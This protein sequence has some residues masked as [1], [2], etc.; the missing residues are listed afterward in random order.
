M[1]RSTKMRTTSEKREASRRGGTIRSGAFRALSLCVALGAGLALARGEDVA[2]RGQSS[3]AGAVVAAEGERESSEPVYAALAPG[4]AIA[5][6]A[7]SV[8]SKPRPVANPS[9]SADSS[10]RQDFRSMA[11]GS[12]SE[13][14]EEAV[15][16]LLAIDDVREFT[17]QNRPREN[18]DN[19]LDEL[20]YLEELNEDIE[21]EE[22]LEAI[23]F[24]EIADE[25]FYALD[26]YSSL[27]IEYPPTGAWTESVLESVQN[28][29]LSLGESSA[30]AE[31]A[32][33]SLDAKIAEA[34]ALREVLIASDRSATRGNDD[35]APKL[36]SRYS[37][38]GRVQLLESF[39]NALRRRAYLWRASLGFFAAEREGS[40]VAPRDFSTAE[41][42]RLLRATESARD[43]FGS[44]PN[45][46]SWRA[47]FDVDLLAEDVA[48]V[49][50]LQTGTFEPS[51]AG[52]GFGDAAE[53][54]DSSAG[55]KTPS[56]RELVAKERARRARF[57]RDRLNSIAR[58]IEKT[59]M[60]PE[61]RQVFNRPA[62]AS[63]AEIAR[64]RACDQ[65][66]AKTLL[67]EFE[68]YENVGGGQSGRALQQLALRMS[69]S[70]S[71]VCRRVGRAIDVLYDNPNVK[72][73]VSEALINRMLPI[74]DPEFG[75][76]QERILNNP[77]AG[78]RRV[79]T[80]VSIELIPDPNRLLMNLTV[81]GRVSTKTSS[82]VLAAKL[83][84]QSYANYVGKKTLEWRDYGIAY[85]PAN[86]AANAVNR[87][88][89]VETDVDF[90]PL[91]GGIAR[92]VARA[93][94]ES[95][96][97]EIRAEMR[98]RVTKEARERIDAEAN[99]RFD[100]L[101]E[102]LRD[103]FFARLSKLGLSLKTQRSKTTDDWLLASLR[104]GSDY[105]LG[106]QSTEPPTLD[107]A[108][109]DFKI[110]ESAINAY[111]TQLDL[112]GRELTPRETLDYLATK[113]DRPALRRIKL[114]END[115]RFTF[116][117]VDPIV[118]RF[119]EDQVR[120]KLRF[121]RMALGKTEWSDLEVEV[122]Y[123]PSLGTDQT[124]SFAR[125]G[126][127]EIYGPT[128]LHS[129]LPLRAILAKA[130]PAQRTFDLNP[131]FFQTDDRFVGLKLGLCRVSR[132][133]F[134]V[135]VVRDD[136]G[137]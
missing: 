71:E 44:S 67:Y 110:H 83:R 23:T 29:L 65:A 61:Q 13:A 136:Y 74:K 14:A 128:N 103:N 52:L 105:S 15:R 97:E 109:A 93:Q 124:P 121:E 70:K 94:Y 85:S 132:G 20:S 113:L 66:S 78:S 56:K 42:V 57:L 137:L 115:L 95:R 31:E 84:N 112:A 108:F 81:N 59:P 101:N 72:A 41:L 107:G 2:F 68:R 8:A 99:E 18:E 118:V 135:S 25:C 48:S 22:K 122:A 27:F 104:L 64:S 1:K 92:E 32:L 16:E 21:T 91:A 62:V 49:L 106:C 117:K 36:V 43:F 125:D 60:T 30:R 87:L 102:R 4:G 133:W 12:R 45:G 28:A 123:R 37:A 134:A 111:L 69:T 96:Q 40:L 33:D 5:A 53:F 54:A 116:A 46:L 47:S 24:E 127:V 63:W 80:T 9:R 50:E 90:V 58:K 76:V 17:A 130:F 6:R 129:L 38:A 131:E 100:A 88:D 26:P 89:A 51:N 120:L 86:V 34:D 98:A 82:E 126:V 39:K 11:Y 10:A 3:D 55:T 19:D 73:Y 7:R 77:V 35:D 79:D 114:E 119:F 75:V